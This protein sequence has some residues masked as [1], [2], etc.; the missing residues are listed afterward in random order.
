MA[1][2]TGEERFK[3]EARR[4]VDLFLSW[5]QLYG[6][7]LAPYTSHTM[8]RVVFMISLTTNSI[9]RY[10]ALDSDER[11]KKLIVGA[12]DDL[13]AHCL[14]PGGV[15]WYKELPS[16]RRPLPSPHVLE[17]LTHAYRL[18]GN[19]RYLKVAARQFFE[20]VET[21]E[22]VPAVGKK[23]TE[24]GAVVE[25]GSL[26]GRPFADKYTSVILFAGAATPEGMLD[27]FEYPV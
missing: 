1:L 27:W 14:G 18:T 26:S 15:F 20:M 25:S 10:L 17:T 7:M 13:L 5:D 16:L 11:V 3:A 6:G 21:N 9:A 12:A 24:Q 2:A 4:L 8:P 22:Q 23:W 19:T